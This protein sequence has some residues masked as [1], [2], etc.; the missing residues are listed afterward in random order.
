MTDSLPAL[1]NEMIPLTPENQKVRALDPYQPTLHSGCSMGLTD[2]KEKLSKLLDIWS[3]SKTFPANMLTEFKTRLL[4]PAAA[5][6][7]MQQMQQFQGVPATS[8]NKP[9]FSAAT[10]PANLLAALAAPPPA[11]APQQQAAAPAPPAANASNALY[12]ALGLAAPAQQQANPPAPLPYAQNGPNVT[13]PPQPPVMSQNGSSMGLQFNGNHVAPPPPPSNPNP[14]AAL[15]PNLQA[16]SADQSALAS[17]ISQIQALHALSQLGPDALKTLAAALN[18]G[19][20][21]PHGLPAP[22]PV[23]QLPVA[24]AG[25]QPQ[26]TSMGQMP[27]GNQAYGRDDTVQDP[28]ARSRSP[29][30]KRRRFSPP[31]R[32]D[33]PTYGTYDPGAPGNDGGRG[34]EPERGGRRGRKGIRNDYRQR[35]PPNGRDRDEDSLPRS[36]QPKPI[37]FDPKL[38]EGQ[39]KGIVVL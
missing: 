21:Q 14:L 17:Q 5:A 19:G 16:G 1:M 3:T 7:Q 29:D 9:V 28:R 6:P 8:A 15:F 39:I 26:Y 10:N 27:Q 30:F 20:L 36:I 32:R 33:S 18:G 31:N 2:S 11:P 13:Y 34:S 23:A 37:G 25:Q 12:A 4:N 22:A 35:S 38:A 24:S